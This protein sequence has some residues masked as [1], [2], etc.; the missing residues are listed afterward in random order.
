MAATVPNLD[1]NP[2]SGRK[3][4]KSQRI[5]SLAACLA[6]ASLI[7]PAGAP[8]QAQ[9][10]LPWSGYV[11]T[12]FLHQNR[13][14]NTG[15]S[16]R[17]AKIWWKGKT[18]F[19]DS[20][21]YKVQAIFRQKNAGSLVLQDAYAEYQSS[22]FIIKFGQMVP[23]FSLQ[24]SQPD[25][26]IPVIERAQ[27][28]DHLIPSAETGARDIG[29]QLSLSPGWHSLHISIGAFNGNGG[30]QLKNE[31]RNF[32]VTHRTTA[33]FYVSP[34]TQ[35]QVGY[36]LAYRKTTGLPFKKIFAD[37]RV[38]AGED[39]RSGIEFRLYHPRWGLQ[40][41]Y[42]RA[43]LGHRISWG[44]YVLVNY[45]FLP[46]HE[47]VFSVDKFHDLSAKTAD[48]PWFILGYNFYPRKNKA[49]LMLDSRAQFTQTR[50][51]Y[52]LAIQ[53]QLMFN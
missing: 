26:R 52:Q 30:N 16:I 32:L 33:R 11:Q 5:F 1:R 50:T 17:R 29:L 38:F 28:I 27:A 45:K 49:K 21:S 31:D 46:K 41:E 22:I 18:P 51:N 10:K 44:S 19:A 6:A 2:L 24:R 13:S 47:L 14:A 39:F 4:Q 3:R 15:F 8:V 53:L 25:Y 37:N 42:I 40:A 36:S 20:W 48:R 43:R 34:R 9:Q 12:R 35:L 23:N 7:L